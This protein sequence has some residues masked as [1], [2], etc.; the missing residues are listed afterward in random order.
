MSLTRRCP[1][2]GVTIPN[3]RYLCLGSWSKLNRETQKRLYRRDGRALARYSVLIDQIENQV[4]WDCIV[5]PA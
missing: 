1:C 3:G 4:S 5:V 2:C